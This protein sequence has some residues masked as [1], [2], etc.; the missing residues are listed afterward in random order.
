M[1]RNILHGCKSEPFGSYLKALGVFRLLS[2]QADGTDVKAWWERG[3]L[4]VESTLRAEE[5]IRFFLDEYV[6]TPIIGPWNGGSGFYEGDSMSARETMMHS[7]DHRFA[8]YKAAFTTISGWKWMV[9]NELTICSILEGLEKL[10]ESMSGKGQEKLVE[11]VRDCNERIDRCVD[12]DNAPQIHSLLNMTVD[13]LGALQ[14]N[15]TGGLKRSLTHL[16]ESIK[17]ARTALNTIFRSKNKKRI[18]AACRAELDARALAWIDAAVMTGAEQTLLYPPILGTGGNEGRLDYTNNFLQHACACLLETPPRQRSFNL[19]AN[20][21]FAESTSELSRHSAG[22]YDPG[23]AGGF[24]QGMGIEN[25]KTANNPWNFIL[26]MEGAICWA[27]GLTRRAHPAAGPL[28]SSPFTVAARGVGYGSAHESDSAQARAEIWTPLWNAPATYPEIRYLIGEGRVEIGGRRARHTIEFAEAASGLGV[29]RGISA[30]VRYGLLKRRGD[31]FVAMP[32]GQFPVRS[33]TE[34]DLLRQLNPILDRIDSFLRRFKEVPARF[35]SSRRAIDEAVYQVCLHGG[36]PRLKNLLAAIGRFE[37]LLA[38]RGGKGNPSLSRPLGGLSPRWL[39]CSDDHSLEFR[40]AAALA[41]IFETGNVGPI[42]ANLEP[43]D[44]HKPWQWTDSR[45]QTAWNGHNLP[46]RLTGVLMRRMMDA[47]RLDCPNN[48]LAGRL[49]LA[50]HDIAAFIAG[51]VNDAMIEDLL[52]GMLW[53]ERGRT[54]WKPV[55]LELRNRWSTPVHHWT[56][57]RSWLLLKLCFLPGPININAENNLSIKHEHAV[58][59]MLKANRVRD[60]CAVAQRRLFAAGLM[61]RSFSIPDGEDG[62]RIAAALLL[63]ARILSKRHLSKVLK[64]ES[65]SDQLISATNGRTSPHNK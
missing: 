50:P 45:G 46:T 28:L 16:H 59:P 47:Q 61:P 7:D 37:K 34:T 19:L 60:A 9:P 20:A 51:D 53:I 48:P 52:F 55:A 39:A 27:S 41:A 1:S 32:T 15:A 43:V 35:A 18:I 33:G 6:P 22:Q 3:F 4:H 26:T 62:T 44:P 49:L 10:S 2:E 12:S 11:T 17:K 23:N 38:D 58:I 13:E 8:P 40:L 63:P 5:V 24:N 56:I 25:K 29:D 14:K 31:S 36:A 30:F 42:R 54:H 64:M 65:L 21:L 57:P